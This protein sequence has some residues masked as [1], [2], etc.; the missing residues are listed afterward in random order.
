VNRA[1]VLLQRLPALLVLRTAALERWA[2]VVLAGAAILLGTVTF[3]FISK[4]P[5]AGGDV[6]RVVLLLNLDVLVLVLLGL[7]VGRRLWRVLRERRLGIAGSRLHARLV[8]LF[9]LLAVTPGILVA[10][11]AAGFLAAGLENWFG[12]RIATAL[13]NSLRVARAYLDEHR[14]TIR[15]DAL[16]MAAD[17]SRDL[18]FVLGD[19]D[20][21]Q[22]LMDAQAALRALSEAVVFE[23]GGRVLVRS[24]LSF[25]LDV[26]RLPLSAL[27]AADRGEVVVLTS[28]S[29]DRVRALLRLE[30][31]GG[32]YLVVGRFV[33][34]EVLGFVERTE[35]VVGEYDD[36]RRERHAIQLRLTLVFG[37]V[38]LL[39]MLA[40]VWAGIA[41]A[42]RIALPLAH[43]AAAAEQ[44]RRGDLS[45]RV[46]ED[47]ANAADEIGL[48]VRTFNRMAE[49]LEA[50][51]R[52]LV[53]A[54]RTLDARRR[55]IEAILTGVSAG[56][57]GLDAD[58][59][60]LLANPRA[61]AL[62]AGEGEGLVGRRLGE[63]LPEAAALPG[64]AAATGVPAEQQ[65]RLVRS[66]HE[67]VLLLRATP[68]LEGGRLAGFVLT[69]DD[70]T[71]LIVAQ[72]QAAWAEV[73]RRIAHEIR[74]PLTPIRLSAERLQRRY[75]KRLPEEERAAFGR[76]VETI[77]RQVDAI[78]RLVF[79]FSAFARMPRPV[80]REEDLAE[81]VREA[82]E[83][84]RT[85]APRVRFVADL[86]RQPLRLLL[87]R[88]KIVQALTNLLRNATEALEEAATPEPRI[89]VRMR[90]EDGWALV[91]VCDNGPGLPPGERHRLFEPYVTTKAR[92]SGLGLAIVRRIV[93]EHAGRVELVDRPG[94]GTCARILLPIRHSEA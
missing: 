28:E 40:A 49:R 43:L 26:S 93:E 38:T 63:V 12:A 56:V 78:G 52:E 35:Q 90:G 57:L 51:Q 81:A 50:Q 94:G 13:E 70:I 55:F 8:A 11:F 39:L 86:P 5:P 34:P 88:E 10:V 71:E 77:V 79:E 69:F 65:L 24:G 21:V 23:A 33:D 82:L 73:A 89:E 85:R 17:L 54:N 20:Q 53:D 64:R 42:D 58:G 18:P 9:G 22:R 27:E 87:D 15:A 46:P 83:L 36:L 6:R 80:L 91:E 30:G 61:E 45:A 66:G 59:R 44:L 92:G 32:L 62:L 72:R 74:N 48:V 75:A 47:G 29:D 37:L 25:T 68:Q 3:F 31:L 16:A 1:A 14:E 84:E 60:I 7:V 19:P 4:A 2:A 67:Y 76:A 41:V